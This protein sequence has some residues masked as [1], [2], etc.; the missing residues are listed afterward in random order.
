MKRILFL[1]IDG[2][3]NTRPG[4]LDEDKLALLKGI[5][6][7]TQA[8]AVISSSWRKYTHMMD[9]L[10]A[11][12]WLE[13]AICGHTPDL[14]REVNG[15]WHSPRRAEEI[16]EWL[17]GSKEPHYVILDDWPMQ[18]LSDRH[19]Q[20]DPHVGLTKEQSDKAIEMLLEKS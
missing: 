8:R 19:I 10:Y 18:E 20:T 12:D 1:D 4:S 15:L 6:D 16:I 17:G 13:E 7:S 2:V 9:R 11:I 5:L 3:L 14:A